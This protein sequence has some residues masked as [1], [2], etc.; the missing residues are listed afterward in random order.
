MSNE[1]IALLFDAMVE[2]VRQRSSVKHVR[3]SLL[4]FCHSSKRLVHN[5]ALINFQLSTNFY[6][7]THLKEIKSWL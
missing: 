7:T 4:K 5:F 2:E 1:F 6:L 3:L